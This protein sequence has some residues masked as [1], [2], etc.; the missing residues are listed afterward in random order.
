MATTD[1]MRQYGALQSES[2]RLGIIGVQEQYEAALLTCALMALLGRS[3][4]LTGKE[5]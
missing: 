3:V 5:P 4:W 2:L 1:P